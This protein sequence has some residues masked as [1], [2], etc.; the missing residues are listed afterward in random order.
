MPPFRGVG[1]APRAPHNFTPTWK[2]L[3][4]YYLAGVMCRGSLKVSGGGATTLPPFNE[5]YISNFNANIV[6]THLVPVVS[7]VSSDVL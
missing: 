4:I 6:N 7:E 2:R 1:S 5:K 3:G